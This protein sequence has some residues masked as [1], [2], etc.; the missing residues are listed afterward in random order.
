MATEHAEPA[1]VAAAPSVERSR[2]RSCGLVPEA[3]APA[4]AAQPGGAR[5]RA[6]F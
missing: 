4:P 6:V 1:F 5:V 2:G 3:R